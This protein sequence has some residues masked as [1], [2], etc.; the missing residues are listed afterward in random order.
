MIQSDKDPLLSLLQRKLGRES[1]R[2]AVTAANLANVETPGYRAQEVHFSESLRAAMP[3]EL[4]RAGTDTS[5]IVDAP[6][7]RI[8]PDGNTVDIDREMTRMAVIQ[9]KFSTVTQLVKKRFALLR[10]AVTDGKG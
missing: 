9:G 8:R 10:Y 5:M 2:A 4:G 1:L 6:S 7:P 3:G